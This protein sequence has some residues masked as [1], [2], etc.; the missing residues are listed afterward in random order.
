MP[1]VVTEGAAGSSVF[2]MMEDVSLVPWFNGAVGF[3]RDDVADA[4]VKCCAGYAMG[5]AGNTA[6]LDALAQRWGGGYLFYEHL[7]AEDG[8]FS[9]AMVADILNVVQGVQAA[10]NLAGVLADWVASPP[11]VE[12]NRAIINYFASGDGLIP[13]LKHLTDGPSTAAPQTLASLM[14]VHQI[15]AATCALIDYGMKEE[16]TVASTLY[17]EGMLT[18]VAAVVG[19]DEGPRLRVVN[20]HLKRAFAAYVTLCLDTDY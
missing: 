11:P 6:I 13:L 5:T 18:H 9:P 20:E 1:L 14:V 7:P 10:D 3:N 12:P 19:E 8:M 17:Y 15:E 4:I 2:N 16:D